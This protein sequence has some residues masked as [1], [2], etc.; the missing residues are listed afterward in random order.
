MELRL[1]VLA[2]FPRSWD[3]TPRGNFLVSFFKKVGEYPNL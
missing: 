2:N 3:P 1:D